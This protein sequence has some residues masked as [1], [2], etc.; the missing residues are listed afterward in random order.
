[1]AGTSAATREAASACQDHHVAGPSFRQRRD[2]V[3]DHQQV[4]LG[5]P[6]LV[7]DRGGRC[8]IEMISARPVSGL[9]CSARVGKMKCCAS[10]RPRRAE[11][12]ASQHRTDHRGLAEALH[13]LTQA[14]ADHQQQHD[15]CDEKRFTHAVGYRAVAERVARSGTK[16]GARVGRHGDKTYA[17][18]HQDSGMQHPPHLREP[19]RAIHVDEHHQR[20]H[21]HRR[22]YDSIEIVHGRS[23]LNAAL[24]RTRQNF[25]RGRG[26]DIA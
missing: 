16:A 23:S 1:M 11:D 6:H 4:G 3:A 8:V 12:Q 10:G 7:Q 2:R 24:K 5:A 14:A 15:L 19:G 18:S 9:C 21:D 22:H 26:F 13:H 20:T 25:V 17:T